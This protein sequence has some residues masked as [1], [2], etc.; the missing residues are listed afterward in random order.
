MA[1]SVVSHV[2]ENGSEVS[3]QGWSVKWNADDAFI[4]FEIELTKPPSIG[5]EGTPKFYSIFRGLGVFQGLSGKKNCATSVATA[6]I[7]TSGG[8][9]LLK[10]ALAN[11]INTGIGVD[12]PVVRGRVNTNGS[13]TDPTQC[14]EK[15]LYFVAPSYLDELCPWGWAIGPDGAVYYTSYFGRS[16]VRVIG[17]GLPD[18]NEKPGTYTIVTSCEQ[19]SS[20]ATYLAA[21]VDRQVTSNCPS[22]TLKRALKFAGGTPVVQ[23]I[24]DLYSLWQPDVEVIEDRIFVFDCIG[25]EAQQGAAAQPMYISLSANAIAGVNHKD[26]DTERSEVIDHVVVKGTKSRMNYLIPGNKEKPDL[27][28]TRTLEIAQLSEDVSQTWTE[29]SATDGG[30]PELAM[31]FTDDPSTPIGRPDKQRKKPD[32]I[33]HSEFYHQDSKDKSKLILLREVTEMM[34]NSLGMLSKVETKNYYTSSYK[35]VGSVEEEYAYVSVPGIPADVFHLCKRTVVDQS[36]ELVALKRS[37]VKQNVEEKCIAVWRKGGTADYYIQVVPLLQANE[38]DL[39]VTNPRTKQQIH[40]FKTHTKLTHLNRVTDG[41]LRLVTVDYDHLTGAHRVHPQTIADP[42]EKDD[43]AKLKSETQFVH[44]VYNGSPPYKKTVEIEH[45]DIDSVEI[46]EAVAQ[47]IFARSGQQ[48][49]EVTVELTMPIPGLVASA[50]GTGTPVM[51]H[52]PDICMTCQSVLA[53]M[54]VS[55]VRVGEP[56]TVRT[57]TQIPGGDY[58]LVAAEEALSLSDDGPHFTCRLTLRN[59]L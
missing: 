9:Q 59:V 3:A 46:A 40:E 24:I 51:V 20:I 19:H 32:Y 47:R 30:N 29:Q 7:T 16:E 53:L 38:Q 39:V 58:V 52:I 10:N 56:K 42:D 35:L 33:I 45:P 22:L 27:F 31:I 49:R 11:E 28:Q 14:L 50:T 18:R 54:S 41:V 2:L 6:T 44:H 36:Q 12:R 23:A 57:T 34:S 13:A 25:S 17:E 4:D 48:K 21:L 5:S 8:Q 26:L 15:D 43:N 1:Y 55:G 37:L